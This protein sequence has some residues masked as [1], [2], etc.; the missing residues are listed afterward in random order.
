MKIFIARYLSVMQLTDEC[1]LL[2]SNFEFGR[3]KVFNS[4][5]PV[6]REELIRRFY[7]FAK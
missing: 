1:F 3:L 7:L 5:L 2:N 6:K 4:I